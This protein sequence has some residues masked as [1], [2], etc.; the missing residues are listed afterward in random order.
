VNKSQIRIKI[1]KLRKKKKIK[2]FIFNFDL[3]LD[4]LKKRRVSAKIVGGYYPYNY[5]IDILQI[6]EKFEKKKFIIA[7]P[8]IKKNSQMNFFQWSTDDPLGINKFG[9]PE[10]ISKMVKY[11]DVL[12]VPVVAFD[13][14]FNRIGYGGG[15]YDRYIKKIRKRKKVITIGFAYSFQKVNKIPTNNYDIKLDFIITNK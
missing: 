12:L 15:F 13:K 7:L 5:E 6:L 10:P 3:I 14:N 2:K 11:P 4:I 9:I 8:K 1:L